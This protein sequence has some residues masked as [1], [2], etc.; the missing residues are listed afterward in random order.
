VA[1]EHSISGCNFDHG[2]PPDGYSCSNTSGDPLSPW[3]WSRR[4]PPAQRHGWLGCRP[5][6]LRFQMGVQKG[7]DHMPGSHLRFVRMRFK[8]KISQVH[9][10]PVIFNLQGLERRTTPVLHRGGRHLTLLLGVV[11]ESQ[12]PARVPDVASTGEASTSVINESSRLGVPTGR[13]VD[14]IHH[15]WICAARTASESPGRSHEGR[16]SPRPRTPDL[17]LRPASGPAA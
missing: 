15:L 16:R 6:I 2:V 4:R 8:I 9:V 10:P 12:D 17:G 3:S 7:E 5:P 13:N 1:D 14:G 11:E